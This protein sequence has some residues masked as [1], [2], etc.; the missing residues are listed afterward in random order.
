[1]CE[2]ESGADT[3]QCKE[4]VD[5]VGQGGIVPAY[6]ESAIVAK[7]SGARTAEDQS[8]LA[9]LVLCNELLFFQTCKRLDGQS[10]ILFLFETIQR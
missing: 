10:R 9:K 5:I 8:E 7:R 4:C 1:M 2:G 3:L 6:A